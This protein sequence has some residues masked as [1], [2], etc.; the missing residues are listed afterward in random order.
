MGLKTTAK[1]KRS[2]KDVM[3]MLNKGAAEGDMFK[4]ASDMPKDQFDVVLASTGSP[5]LDYKVGGFGYGR[6]TLMTGWEGSGKTSAAIIAAATLQK[7]TGKAVLYYDSENSV[8]NSH[9]DR[10]GINREL[11]IPRKEQELESMLNEVE[12]FSK[13]PDLGMIIIDSIKTF[14]SSYVEEKTAEEHT[15]GVEAKKLN[16]RMPIIMSNCRRNGI[17]LVIINQWRENPASKGD[18][19]VLSGGHWQKFM[20]SLHL[21]FGTKRD[22]ILIYDENKKIIGHTID[23]RVMK[24][25]YHVHGKSDIINVNL[26]YDYGYD[27]YDEY[28]NLLTEMGVIDKGGSWYHFPN[29]KKEQG[30]ENAAAYLSEHPEY[31]EELVE[32]H[33]KGNIPTVLKET[34]DEDS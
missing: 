3:K 7:E 28:C 23:V 5:Y 11:L 33:I 15:I 27:K 25:R 19:R 1:D 4:F 22:K 29:G 24:S 30:K 6:M 10:F 14:F 8:T 21:D 2:L 31:L 17:A 9:M 26:Y 16:A 32:L 18:P 34:E 20:P 13:T 12:A